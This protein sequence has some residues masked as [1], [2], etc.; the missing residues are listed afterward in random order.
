MKRLKSILA[1]IV[2]L[3]LLGGLGYTAVYGLGEDK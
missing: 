1:L 3:A 2:V